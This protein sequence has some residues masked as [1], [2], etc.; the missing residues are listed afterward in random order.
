MLVIKSEGE[1][2]SFGFDTFT[3]LNSIKVFDLIGVSK[4]LKL[5]KKLIRFIILKKILS[6]I[7]MFLISNCYFLYKILPLVVILLTFCM[8]LNCSL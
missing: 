7:L 2:K 8:F 1:K 3:S 6:T 4:Q 5:D